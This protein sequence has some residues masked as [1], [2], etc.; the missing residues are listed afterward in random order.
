MSDPLHHEAPLVHLIAVDPH[1]LDQSGLETYLRQ[2]R[3]MR[4]SPQTARAK[5]ERKPRKNTANI[6]AARG[7]L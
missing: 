2:L 6:D 1:K 5:T 4:A 3:E 7:M